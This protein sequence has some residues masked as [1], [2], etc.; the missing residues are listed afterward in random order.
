MAFSSIQRKKKKKGKRTKE[1]VR[2]KGGR[3]D[4]SPFLLGK[5]KGEKEGNTQK[6]RTK[7]ILRRLNF[8]VG[9]RRGGGVQI[10]REAMVRL[11]Y[12]M[13]KRSRY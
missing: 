2:E 12:A 6:G 9:I 5:E 1:N 7:K 13:K 11:W 3:I 8:L 10:K 4:T